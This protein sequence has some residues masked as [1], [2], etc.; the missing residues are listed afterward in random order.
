MTLYGW[1]EVNIQELTNS[2]VFTIQWPPLKQFQRWKPTLQHYQ[3][4]LTPLILSDSINTL[5]HYQYPPTLSILSNTINTLRHCQYSPTLS[6]LSD[7]I[8]TLRHYQYSP[9]LSILSN[10]IN[11][12]PKLSILSD[13]IHTLRHYQ[14]SLTQS[15]LSDT[16]NTPHINTL[17]HRYIFFKCPRGLTFTWWGR[18][19]SCLGHEPTELAHSLCSVLVSISVFVA[20][21]T[22][23]HSINSPDNSLFSHSV[24][25]VVSLPYWSFQL[26]LFM[27]V[28]PSPDI[29]P[30]GWLGSKH[31]L[32]N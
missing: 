22:V 23:F 10:I 6:V 18:Y 4:S 2:Q 31:Q 3:Y 9:T 12:L 24:L 5:R 15:I 11:T 17:F 14:Y 16:I 29:I 20:L 28:S 19:G 7:T 21:S 30:S 32:T 26:R 13:T 25:P 27:K 8:N 1:Q